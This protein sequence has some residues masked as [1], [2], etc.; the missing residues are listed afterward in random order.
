MPDAVR[1][2]NV[3]LKLAKGHVAYE[4]SEIMVNKPT[5][6]IFKTV[7]HA[8]LNELTYFEKLPKNSVWPEIGSREF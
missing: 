6:L 1:V 7:N 3:L 8:T 2:E 4:Y 5:S